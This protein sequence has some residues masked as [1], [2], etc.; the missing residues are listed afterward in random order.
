[1]IAWKTF[2]APSS[3]ES[4]LVDERDIGGSGGKPDWN[5]YRLNAS[6]NTAAVAISVKLPKVTLC[7]GKSII[8]ITTNPNL[9]LITISVAQ[10]S[11]DKIVSSSVELTSISTSVD[12]AFSMFNCD[13]VRWYAFG[14]GTIS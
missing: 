2:T 11:T 1:M 7:E 12:F 14:D 4:L 5:G 8:F 13:G 10:G 6:N 9:K 3:A